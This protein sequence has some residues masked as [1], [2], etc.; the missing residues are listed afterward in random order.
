MV[1]VICWQMPAP[2][3]AQKLLM[4]HPRTDKVGKCPTVYSCG[5]WGDGCG[6]LEFT[7]VNKRSG[8]TIRIAAT[9]GQ[10]LIH[11]RGKEFSMT[12]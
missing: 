9:A 12:V 1:V 10:S 6:Q 7:D 5:G 2:G 11:R 8:N 3:A 4:P